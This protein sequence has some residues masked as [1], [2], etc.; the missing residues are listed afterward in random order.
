MEMRERRTFDI[1][2]GNP[3]WT[4][5]GRKGPKDRKERGPSKETRQ[6]RGE[7]LYF[8]LRAAEFGHGETR[9]VVVL[10]AMP[11]FAGSKTGAA[12]ARYVVEKLAGDAGQPRAAYEVAVPDRQDA[13]VLLL[14]RHRP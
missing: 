4:F 13:A 14:A 12:A 10:S 9:Y 5:R 6:P 3:L 2:V 1:V 7:G 8:V 11:F